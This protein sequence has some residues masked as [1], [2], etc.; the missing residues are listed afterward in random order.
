MCQSE[1]YWHIVVGILRRISP[2]Q[3][4]AALGGPF[5]YALIFGAMIQASASATKRRL[6]SRLSWY[7]PMER[8]NA[9]AILPLLG[10]GL[11]S[12]FPSWSVL[13]VLYAV[14]LNVW[15]LWQG[16]TYWLIKL[17]ILQG[18]SVDQCV[19]L[20]RFNRWRHQNLLGFYPMLILAPIVWYSTP[21]SVVEVY[22]AFGLT[23]L[24]V[25]EHINYYHVQLM[26]DNASDVRYFALNKRLKEASLA[27]D[28]RQGRL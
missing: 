24:A 16:S 22:W 8:L 15:L 12:W 6:I 7:G 10:I 14:G 27:K 18:E 13:P 9:M 5:F 23:L 28:L 26:I 25:A 17:K 3:R 20:K 1:N 21:P 11:A 2:F 4:S 19:E